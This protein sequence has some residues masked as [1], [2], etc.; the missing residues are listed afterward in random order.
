DGFPAVSN[1]NASDVQSANRRVDHPLILLIQMTCRLVEENEIGSAVKCPRQKEPLLLPT[2]YGAPHIP[3][4]RVITHRHG[5]H[6]SMNRGATRRIL[7]PP[8]VERIGKEANVLG[9]A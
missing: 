7:Y 4:E 2:G 6:F 1:D 3:N 8:H 9:N 5:H